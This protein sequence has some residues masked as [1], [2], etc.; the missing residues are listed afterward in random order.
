MR[1]Q[2]ESLCPAPTLTTRS[3]PLYQVGDVFTLS[4]ELLT[5]VN[6]ARAKMNLYLYAEPVKVWVESGST[7]IPCAF[8]VLQKP[9]PLH[10]RRP[11]VHFVY[12]PEGD[13]YE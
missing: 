12:Y 9:C 2:D 3:Q 10:C 11:G 5:E 7:C 4:G 8:R 6:S 1:T 13:H